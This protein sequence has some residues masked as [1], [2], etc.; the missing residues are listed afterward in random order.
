MEKHHKV[1]RKVSILGGMALIAA[2]FS[3]VANAES[4]Y[5]T[6]AGALTATAHVD[7]SIVIPKTLYLRVGTGTANATNA[8]VN[9]VTFTV[10]AANVGDSTVIS[11]TGG[12]LTGGVVT[13]AVKGNSGNITL[14]ATAPAA[15]SDGAGD[16]IDWSEITTTAAANTTATTLAAPTL[17]TSSTTS[18]ALTATGKVVNQDAKWTYQYANSTIP[19]AGTYGGVNTNNSRVT[20][21]VSLP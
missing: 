17:T 14:T 13:A 19:A 3:G 6:G 11:G 21:S 5:Q 15:I 7:F 8:A 9:L 18:V 16:S 10:P 20:Y 4:N 12:D 2:A 1:I